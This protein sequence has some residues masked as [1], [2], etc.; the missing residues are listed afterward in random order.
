LLGKLFKKEELGNQW[1]EDSCREVRLVEKFGPKFR[2]GTGS[3]VLFSCG[4]VGR[5]LELVLTKE[6][7]GELLLLF[8]EDREPVCGEPFGFGLGGGE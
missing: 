7:K 1:S 5:P 6:V 2:T 8:R 3:G 4:G